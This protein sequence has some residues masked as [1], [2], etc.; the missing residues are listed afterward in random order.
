MIPGYLTFRKIAEGGFS[1][2]YSA[3]EANLGRTVAV[4]ILKTEL[5]D[6]VAAEQFARE[7]LAAGRLTGHPNIITIFRAGS[8]KS[9]LPFIAMQYLPAGSIADRIHS[10]GPLP[11]SDTLLI[12]ANIADALNF[13]H[14]ENIFHGDVKPGNILL[15][16]TGQPILSDFGIA[17][18]SGAYG[19]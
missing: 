6:S 1:T 9:L 5:Q 10:G 13:A 15:T 7:C 16:D 19:L 2:V 17:S 8:T 18:I 12:G 4:K 3:F 14:T 11:V